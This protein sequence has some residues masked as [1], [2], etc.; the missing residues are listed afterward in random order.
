MKSF[1]GLKDSHWSKMISD[2]S[3]SGLNVHPCM[4]ACAREMLQATEPPCATLEIK[5]HYTLCTT[6]FFQQLLRS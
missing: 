3:T 1:K 5:S 6:F 4:F 2:H